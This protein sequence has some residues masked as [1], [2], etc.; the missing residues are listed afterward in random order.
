[1]QCHQPPKATVT[2]LPGR[3]DLELAAIRAALQ[4]IGGSLANMDP[5]RKKEMKK[6]RK[7]R[8]KKRRTLAPAWPD[9]RHNMAAA[10][11]AAKL[12]GFPND[13]GEVRYVTAEVFILMPGVQ[14]E[15]T[16]I[17]RT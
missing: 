3:F 2:S 11:H 13:D 4:E 7:K 8:R 12:A 14:A 16:T 10:K 15:R 1:V 17:E 5:K 6:A 9:M